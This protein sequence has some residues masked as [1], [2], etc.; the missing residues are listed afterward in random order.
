MYLVMQNITN[1]LS[2]SCDTTNGQVITLTL[3]SI[4]FG[5]ILGVIAQGVRAKR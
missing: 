2:A 5:L 4:L 3:S 1:Y